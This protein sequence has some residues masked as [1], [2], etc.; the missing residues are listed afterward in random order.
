MSKETYVIEEWKE[1]TNKHDKGFWDEI[2]DT[3]DYEVAEEIY[4]NLSTTGKFRVM[5]VIKEQVF[6]K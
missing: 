6:P 2:H 4:K 1:P 5:K 3:F